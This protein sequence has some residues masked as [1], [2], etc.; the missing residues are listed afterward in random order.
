MTAPTRI[1]TETTQQISAAA[2]GVGILNGLHT[3]PAGTSLLLCIIFLEG[4]EVLEAANPVTFEG[5]DLTEITDTGLTG[6]NDDIRAYAFG[7]VSPGEVTDGDTVVNWLFS[8]QPVAVIWINYQDTKTGSVADAVN[9]ISQDINT[10]LTNQSVLAGGGT[11]GNTLVAAGAFQGND[12]N[13]SSNDGGFTEFVEYE[14]AAT[15][16]DFAVNISELTAGVPAAVNINWSVSD[17]NTAILIELVA[18]TAGA[19]PISPISA[20][21]VI[22]NP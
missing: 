22:V 8:A 11:V 15:T 20:T 13:P 2:S 6:D 3:V 12:G 16:S 18:E 9:S 5:A 19:G 17:E 14:T 21:G 1:G 10:D 4:N 7:M